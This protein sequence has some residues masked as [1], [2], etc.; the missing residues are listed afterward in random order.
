MIEINNSIKN[1][2]KKEQILKLVDQINMADA[3]YYGMIASQSKKGY[4][5]YKRWRSR[6]VSRINR[7]NGKKEKT[8]WDK[9]KRKSNKI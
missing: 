8:V 1:K 2:N 7:I 9:M 3:M 4:P 5:V 6:I